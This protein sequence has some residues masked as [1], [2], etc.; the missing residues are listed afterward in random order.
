MLTA[1]TL[2]VVLVQKYRTEKEMGGLRQAQGK[3][4]SQYEFLGP[5]G[6]QTPEYW[7]RLNI[8]FASVSRSC[9]LNLSRILLTKAKSAKSVAALIE[10][11]I[12][13]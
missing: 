11:A 12:R 8:S 2:V 13:K 5:A 6:S 3:C 4:T 7:Y 1:Q 10:P 9:V